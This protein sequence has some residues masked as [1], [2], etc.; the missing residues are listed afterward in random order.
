MA[1]GHLGLEKVAA[2]LG[3][4][5]VV[6][7]GKGL[8]E[9]GANLGVLASEGPENTDASG[10]LGADLGSLHVL[11]RRHFARCSQRTDDGCVGVRMLQGSMRR[12]TRNNMGTA[13]ADF[14]VQVEA[15]LCAI[16]ARQ[17]DH[18]EFCVRVAAAGWGAGSYTT[19]ARRT[20]AAS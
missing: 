13:A 10:E 18:E 12:Q 9:Q 2:L 5:A 20:S 3:P 8:V 19:G 7:A 17:I 14:D 4:L 16:Q 6:V 11:L 1:A 15:A